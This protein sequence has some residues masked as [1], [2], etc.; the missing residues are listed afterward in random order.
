VQTC[1]FCERTPAAGDTG[2]TATVHGNLKA[3]PPSG[4]RPVT[5]D[6]SVARVAITIP[7]CSTCAR[8]QRRQSAITLAG[9][10]LGVV[11]L[12][13][14]YGAVT[15]LQHRAPFELFG[16]AIATAITL[17]AAGFLGGLLA[18]VL[19]SARVNRGMARRDPRTHPEVV[20]L[21]G[22]GWSYDPPGG[23]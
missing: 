19:V 4:G 16:G 13:G 2:F 18:G 3:L 6:G 20:A 12:A 5:S 10:V 21:T 9:L 8:L 15:L 17:G 22:A 23:E 7:R 1:W 14:T 11:L